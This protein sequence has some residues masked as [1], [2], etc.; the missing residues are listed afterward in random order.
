M[1]ISINSPYLATHVLV[2]EDSKM[3]AISVKVSLKRFNCTVDFAE[4]GAKGVDKA[5]NNAYDLILMDIGL[6]DIDGIK[7]TQTIR[8]FSDTQKAHVPIFGLTGHANNPIIRQ[9]CLNAGMQEVYSKPAQVSA[10]CSIFQRFIFQADIALPSDFEERGHEASS[11]QV[12]EHNLGASREPIIDWQ[13]CLEMLGQNEAATRELLSMIS[14]EL[15]P[16]WV[17]LSKCYAERD[18]AGLRAELHSLLGGVVCA[19][20]PHLER[21]LKAFQT[22]VKAELCDFDICEQTY[23]TLK[24]A[25]DDFQ[26]EWKSKGMKEN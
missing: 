13:G 10:L 22:A 8:S 23:Q 24:K 7:V 1:A 9:R 20:L 5:K 17:I 11:H 4:D 21:A 3:A 12:D 18:V 16:A 19:R 2:V 26:A 6:P 25:I 14:T 15:N